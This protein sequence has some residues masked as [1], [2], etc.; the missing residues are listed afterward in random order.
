[1]LRPATGKWFVELEKSIQRG[2][3]H[4]GSTRAP[5]CRLRRPRRNELFAADWD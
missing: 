5:A 2:I 1:M 3:L 4:P